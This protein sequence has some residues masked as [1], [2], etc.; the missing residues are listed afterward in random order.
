MAVTVEQIAID[1]FDDNLSYVIADNAH[2]EAHIVDPSGEIDRVHAH[3]DKRGL[4]VTGILITHTH[5]DHIERLSDAVRKYPNAYVYVHTTGAP[6]LSV[7]GERV[8]PV[9]GGANLT[10]GASHIHVL[11]IPGHSDDS[12][13]F[14]IVMR[15][16]ADGVPKVV[17]GDTLFVDGCG[18]T[19]SSG[20]ADLYASLSELA[21]LPYETEVYPGHDYGSTPYS[22]IGREKADNRFLAADTLEEFTKLRLG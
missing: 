22:T 14:Y 1:G 11:H 15:E 4:T 12:I 8:V 6:R 9:E 5:F 10:L 2:A 16:A 13:C 3:V 20:V 19:N 18:R 17:T 21:A 7:Q